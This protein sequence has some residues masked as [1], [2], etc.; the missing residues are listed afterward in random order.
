MIFFM[1]DAG[2]T[3]GSMLAF[4]SPFNLKWLYG[5]ALVHAFVWGH[6][7]NACWISIW[8][9]LFRGFLHVNADCRGC[10]GD[11]LTTQRWYFYQVGDM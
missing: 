4:Q 8:W 1:T 10:Q 6:G 11:I 9:M 2:A 5:F 7:L 3:D